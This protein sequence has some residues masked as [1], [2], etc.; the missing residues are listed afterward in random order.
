MGRVGSI[1]AADGPVG[2]VDR[3][4]VGA[5]LGRAHP[6]AAWRIASKATADANSDHVFRTNEW[7]RGGGL[8]DYRADITRV[9]RLIGYSPTRLF[10]F[11]H[12]VGIGMIADPAELSAARNHFL[13]YSVGVFSAR[14]G[15]IP[16]EGQFT[17]T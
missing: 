11:G 8:P 12:S 17:I 9:D 2:L 4:G 7:Y 1:P 16:N 6:I 10:P 14:S 3:S 13:K 15:N 5:P